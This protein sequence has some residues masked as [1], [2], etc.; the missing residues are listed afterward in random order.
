MQ[1]VIYQDQ[2]MLVTH[3]Y[4]AFD[5][6]QYDKTVIYIWTYKLSSL[7]QFQFY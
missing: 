2:S 5:Y 7:F 4:Y 6:I 3:T 1:N